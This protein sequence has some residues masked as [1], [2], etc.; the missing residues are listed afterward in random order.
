MSG[1]FYGNEWFSDVAVSSVDEE[2]IW[3]GKV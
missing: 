1:S 2:I 3:Y